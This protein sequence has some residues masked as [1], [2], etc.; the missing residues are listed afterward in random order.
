VKRLLVVIV[1]G[2]AAC[3]GTHAASLGTTLSKYPLCSEVFAE[4][5]KAIYDESG[6]WDPTCK[7]GSEIILGMSAAYNCKDRSKFSWTDRG[8][9][10]NGVVHAG[11]LDLDGDGDLTSNDTKLACPR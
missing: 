11:K 8:W 2:L 10:K 7:D 6:D 9:M 4:G 3:G 5:A 1:L